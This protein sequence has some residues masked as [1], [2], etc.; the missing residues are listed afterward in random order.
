MRV[1]VSLF[2]IAV[3]VAVALAGCAAKPTPGPAVTR[4]FA[5]SDVVLRVE[6]VPAMVASTLRFAKLPTV[7]VYGD[8]RVIT[9]AAQAAVY[10]GPALPAL[11]VQRISTSDVRRLVDLAIAAG[12]GSGQDLG[13]PIVADAPSTR[14]SL[15]ADSGVVRTTVFALGMTPDDKLTA[16]QRAGRTALRDLTTTLSNLGSAL[17]S[18]PQP[19]AFVP[20]AVIA[21]AQDWT[22]PHDPSA[23]TPPEAA[24]PGPALP[25][26]YVGMGLTCVTASGTVGAAV[27]S[28]A[29]HANALTPWTFGGARWT[30]TLRP[31]LPDETGCLDLMGH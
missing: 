31:L 18:V 2:G 22:D 28:A 12:V 4:A 17:G 14:F 20:S 10:P 1:K 8:G 26:T 27:M 29:T 19:V 9:P 11:Q 24:W 5:P 16:A 25:G 7:S 15:L 23:P 6:V 3:A 21:V 30:L 13:S